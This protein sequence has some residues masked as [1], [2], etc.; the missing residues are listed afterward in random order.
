MRHKGKD[1]SRLWK[2]NISLNQ[3]KV[4][5][6]KLN[7]MEMSPAKIINKRQAAS[8]VTSA[9]ENLRRPS[10]DSDRRNSTDSKRLRLYHLTKKR[11]RERDNSARV[12]S[13]STSNLGVG[14]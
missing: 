12:S 4:A 7:L 14:E 10:G 6:A 2:K 8:R 3:K 13:H 11:K 1:I 5:V 9:L